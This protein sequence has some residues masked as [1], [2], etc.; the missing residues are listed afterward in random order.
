MPPRPTY[1]RVEC[2]VPG[3]RRGTTRLENNGDGSVELICG[4][5]WRT[6]P[7]SWRRRIALFKRHVKR[8]D[9]RGDAEKYR[10]A[11]N[12]EWRMWQR[13]RAMFLDAPSSDELPAHLAEHLRDLGL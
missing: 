11:V 3:C 4:R 1:P 5:H 9:R 10:Q 6:V 12:A 7:L 2:L 13:V 8:A